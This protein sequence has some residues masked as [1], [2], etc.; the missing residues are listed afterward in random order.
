MQRALRLA[1]R[2]QL[3]ALAHVYQHHFTRSYLGNCIFR[4]HALDPRTARTALT[5]KSEHSENP[6]VE[7]RELY[8]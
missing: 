2:P 8:S 1:R 4:G 3:H 7:S 6:F 5:Q